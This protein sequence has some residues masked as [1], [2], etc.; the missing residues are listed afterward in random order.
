MIPEEFGTVGE[1][2][3]FKLIVFALLVFAPIVYLFVVYN[4]VSQGNGPHEARDFTWLLYILLLIAIVGPTLARFVERLQLLAYKKGMLQVSSTIALYQS[5]VIP[6]LALVEA[7]YILGL[8]FCFITFDPA[9]LWY[10]YPIGIVWTIIHWPTEEKY[11]EFVRKVE[12]S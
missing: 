3:T 11:R 8:M 5:V 2:W 7:C 4:T 6:K 1:R 10:F 12:A 9:C